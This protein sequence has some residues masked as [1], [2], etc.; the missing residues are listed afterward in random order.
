MLWQTYTKNVINGSRYYSLRVRS[1]QNY[2]KDFGYVLKFCTHPRYFYLH[3]KLQRR[4]W[5]EETNGACASQWRG[6]DESKGDSVASAACNRGGNE[7]KGVWQKT[8]SNTPRINSLFSA[9]FSHDLQLWLDHFTQLP[10]PPC[11]WTFIY[12]TFFTESLSFP[13]P[14]RSRELQTLCFRHPFPL[15]LFL[16]KLPCILPSA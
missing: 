6:R 16:T 11:R 15:T 1:K 14:S 2:L 8:L 10:N 5:N 4:T 12:C 3:C 9:F 13:S 7:K